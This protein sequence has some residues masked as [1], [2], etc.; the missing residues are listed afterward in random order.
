MNNRG[1]IRWFAFIANTH[2][3]RN[4][5]E[6]RERKELEHEN[7]NH[8]RLEHVANRNPRQVAKQR[9]ESHRQQRAR[10]GGVGRPGWE[11]DDGREV[12]VEWQK[13]RNKYDRMF[14]FGNTGKLIAD[15]RPVFF[16]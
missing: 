4:V 13:L 9:L 11:K 8:A 12:D 6:Q 3:Q 16:W 15:T 7:L 1:K 10:L 14:P 2:L 5:L